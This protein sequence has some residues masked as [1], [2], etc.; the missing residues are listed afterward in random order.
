MFLARREAQ[1]F[2]VTERTNRLSNSWIDSR[3]AKTPLATVAEDW[4][5]SSIARLS[6]QEVDASTTG[7]SN[8]K[9]CGM[10][11]GNDCPSPALSRSVI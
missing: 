2:E 4:L 1:A 11:G 3:V 10:P 8:V 7:P 5:E 6:E 9:V